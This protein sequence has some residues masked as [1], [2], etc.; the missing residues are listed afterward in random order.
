MNLWGVP[1]CE[2]RVGLELETDGTTQT[3]M[4]STTTNEHEFARM[5][6]QKAPKTQRGNPGGT[7]EAR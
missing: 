2:F 7:A 4:T 1:S 3:A 6:P 5:K